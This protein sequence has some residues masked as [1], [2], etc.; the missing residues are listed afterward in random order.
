MTKCRPFKEKEIRKAVMKKVRNCN[1]K[2][3]ITKGKHEK[4][5]IYC[6]DKLIL[7]IKVPNEH[8][9]IMYHEKSQY[10]ARDLGVNFEEFNELVQCSLSGTDYYRKICPKTA[11]VAIV[12]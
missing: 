11:P 6:G 8:D 10:I 7:R 12:Q 2:N 3:Y 9:S 1:D 5:Y 4:V